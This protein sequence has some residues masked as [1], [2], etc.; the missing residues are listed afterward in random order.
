[1]LCAGSLA[2][3]EYSAN[4]GS[5]EITFTV[6]E[7]WAG[8]EYEDL[9]FELLMVDEGVPHA[10]SAAPYAGVVYSD[11]CSGAETEEIGPKAADFAAFMADRPGIEMQGEPAEITVGARSGLQFDV[12]AVDPGCESDPPDRVWLWELGG[13]TDFHLSV[14]E[15][16]RL[17]ALDDESGV[18]VLIIETFDPAQ[19][20][21]LL[22]KA[23]PII[24]SMT[25]S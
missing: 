23:Q 18:I 12:D 22:E 2:A 20:D 10:I 5:T 15:A 19:F 21:A 6:D 11:V 8:S 9:G 13:V 1:M 14:G 17:I 24:D 3:G 7:G 4:S 25:F 16:A